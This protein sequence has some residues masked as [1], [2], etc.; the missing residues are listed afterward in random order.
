[1]KRIVLFFVAV[2]SLV[3]VSCVHPARETPAAAE[4][5]LQVGYYVGAGSG[6]A[7]V[8]QLARLLAFSPQL[9]VTLLDAR[10]VREGG[11]EGKDLLVVPG[12]SSATQCRELGEE[13]AE[14]VRRFVAGGGAYFGVCAGFHCAL[15]RE[16]RLQ[17]LPYT[18][19]FGGAGMRALLAIDLSEKAAERLDVPS[20]RYI[21]RYSKGPV[22]RRCEQPGEGWAEE[23]AVYRNAVT[24]PK[25]TF[26]GAPAM[27][28]GEYGKGKIIATSFH[29]ESLA[30]THP[31][32][33]GCVYAVTG[34]RPMPVF[35]AKARN[36]TRVAY[37]LNGVGGNKYWVEQCLALEACRDLDLT[38][39]AT[40][41]EGL[42]DHV[43]VL[44]CPCR[45]GQVYKRF[46][47]NRSLDAQM[48]HFARRGGKVLV[49]EAG[50]PFAPAEWGA[51]ALP[52]GSCPAEAVRR[53]VR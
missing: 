36:R 41:D 30:S 51:Q 47:Q 10:D 32:A 16:Q 26:D 53:L 18:W 14:A 43:D 21:V 39:T 19:Y 5:R 4:K 17:L 24:W 29:P 11:L 34:V 20:G 15:N 2:L 45:N 48:R 31:I 3:A 12:G 13:G 6:G 28:Y 50:L 44:V 52:D 35:P 42:L 9:E 40:L 23:L 38:V 22:A 46:F 7:G 1:M 33:L 8:F 49:S 37:L 27:L 25:I